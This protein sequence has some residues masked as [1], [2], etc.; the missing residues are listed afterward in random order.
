LI[1][2]AKETEA[3]LIFP[4][5]R[6]IRHGTE[7]MPDILGCQGMADEDIAPELSKRNFIPINV[8]V[9]RHALAVVNGFPNPGSP[10]WS[11]NDCEDWG[12]WLRLRDAG[13]TF[14]HTPE[15][16]W[17]WHHWGWGA[18]DQPGNTSGKA[19]RW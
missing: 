12:C 2:R 5:P 19:D 14:S 8:L 9:R 11:H 1:A 17:T 18:P 6:I 3:D 10:E 7:R 4:W 13:F 15:E 16:T